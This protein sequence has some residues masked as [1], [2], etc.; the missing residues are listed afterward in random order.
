MATCTL[1]DVAY[2]S[3]RVGDIDVLSLSS[4]GAARHRDLAGH[5]IADRSRQT[6]PPPS[7]E[8]Y[9]LLRGRAHYDPA[10]GRDPIRTLEKVFAITD[11]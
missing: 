6:S 7:I 8:P 4:T 9:T 3:T 1:L 2:L 11:V 10:P 5:P